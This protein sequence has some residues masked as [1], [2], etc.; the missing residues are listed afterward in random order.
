MVVA[1]FSSGTLPQGTLGHH[2]ANNKTCGF[3]RGPFAS[4]PGY[5]HSEQSTIV[6][7]QAIEDVPGDTSLA[8]EVNH[9]RET[10]L[11][12]RHDQAT[13]HGLLM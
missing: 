7:A 8:K 2:T 10:L 6:N 9:M 13:L 5:T 4:K 1:Q 3:T 11:Q 12:V